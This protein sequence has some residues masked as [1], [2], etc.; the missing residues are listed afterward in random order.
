MP[1][2]ALIGNPNTGKSTLFNA[3]TGLKQKT[4]NYPGV[5]VE[6]HSGELQHGGRTAQLIDLPGVY[7][8]AAQSPD[9]VIAV[10]ALLGHVE[11]LDK[12]RVIIAVADATNLR[13]NL[14]L[15]TQLRELGIPVVLALNMT[16][17][18][19]RQGIHIDASQLGEALGL[20]VVPVTAASGTN[21]D[22]LRDR[23]PPR[24]ERSHSRPS[25]PNPCCPPCMRRRVNSRPGCTPPAPI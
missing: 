20:A 22:A 21:L 7:S 4:A 19:D 6:R 2:V 13:R 17:L 14:F 9:E 23:E 15:V 16:D 3:L 12:P 8:L 1:V 25:S 5:T 18:A 11:D 10:D 24:L